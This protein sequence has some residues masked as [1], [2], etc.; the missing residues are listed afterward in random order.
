MARSANRVDVQLKAPRSASQRKK[1]VRDHTDVLSKRSSIPN[2][3][4]QD[5][6]RMTQTV[7]Q[8]SRKSEGH[9]GAG[10]MASDA[11]D[12]A[13]AVHGAGRVGSGFNLNEVVADVIKFV[14]PLVN[15]DGPTTL[16][17]PS[18]RTWL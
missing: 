4:G 16:W 7:T 2:A 8:Q 12:D 11:L 6:E 1:L 5:A 9:G 3:G 13:S 17:H 18:D 10:G 15:D 14:D